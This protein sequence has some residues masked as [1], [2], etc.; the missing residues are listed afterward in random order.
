MK[1]KEIDIGEPKPKPRRRHSA[2]FISGS[3]VMFGG[4]DGSF[5]NDLNI[6]DLTTAKK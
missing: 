6:M 5:Y 4:F 3:L 2:L 1:W